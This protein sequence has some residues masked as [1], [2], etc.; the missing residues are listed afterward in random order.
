MEEGL[1]EGNLPVLY[2]ELL[3]QAAC[4]ELGDQCNNRVDHRVITARIPVSD[5][6]VE[7]IWIASTELDNWKSLLWPLFNN[8]NRNLGFQAQKD[9]FIRILKE[10]IQ[11]ILGEPL[12]QEGGALGDQLLT[13]KNGLPINT[14][15][16]LMQY[17]L[18]EIKNMQQRCEFNRLVN[19]VQSIHG[20]L[21][22]LT[23]DPTAKV[24][25]SLEDFETPCPNM[26]PKGDNIK[27]LKLAPPKALGADDSYRYD[28]NF[29]GKTI[30]SIPKNFLP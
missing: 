25:Y 15:S 27:R 2:W 13:R 28:H 12:L 30:Y 16:P 17:E 29:R 20:L 26:S 5:K 21:K 10:E 9:E 14:Q 24:A 18:P 6:L 3:K 19:W 1:G 4:R 11:A 7:E 22:R 8:I 23:S